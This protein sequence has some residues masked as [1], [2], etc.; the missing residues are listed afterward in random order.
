[1]NVLC[2]YEL[3]SL[4]CNKLGSTEETTQINDNHNSVQLSTERLMLSI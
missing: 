4:H 1:M 3:S 2:V